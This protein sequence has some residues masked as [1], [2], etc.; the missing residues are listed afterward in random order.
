MSH[1][2]PQ[3]DF[4]LMQSKE[5]FQFIGTVA[6]FTLTVLSTFWS[7]LARKPGT[8]GTRYYAR[9]VLWT[10]VG[11]VAMLGTPSQIDKL[12]FQGAIVVLAV[13]Y[14]WQLQATKR[15]P[16]H[17]H[18]HAIGQWR[19]DIMIELMIAVAI[20]FVL[21]NYAGS[22]LFAPFLAISALSCLIHDGII[23]ERDKLRATQMADAI[24]EQEY[25]MA[26]YERYKR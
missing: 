19:F 3:D 9:G 17:V 7:Q 5:A 16:H 6:V 15:M 10:F 13:A 22:R 11:F 25:M 26:N 14:I 21:W 8:I 24:A 18:T 20:M 2:P 1:K 4:E 23:E 12:L